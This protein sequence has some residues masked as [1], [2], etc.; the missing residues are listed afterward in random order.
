MPL[1]FRYA[2]IA[3]LS[4]AASAFSS[5]G[6]DRGRPLITW[7]L[8]DSMMSVNFLLSY[9]FPGLSNK[10]RSEANLRAYFI[11]AWILTPLQEQKRQNVLPIISSVLASTQWI[12]WRFQLMPGTTMTG[13]L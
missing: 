1:R 2:P 9:S 10:L 13:I 7:I 12:A 11:E 3:L 4:Y 5:V 6:L 8:T